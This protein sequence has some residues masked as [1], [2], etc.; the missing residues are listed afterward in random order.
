MRGQTGIDMMGILP[1]IDS[2]K[3]LDE[4]A[5]LSKLSKLEASEALSESIDFINTLLKSNKNLDEITEAEKLVILNR[6]NKLAKAG[7]IKLAS[8]YKKFG[9]R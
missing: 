5:A 8:K 3:N 1:I 9:V 2:V 4:F 6:L 7:I